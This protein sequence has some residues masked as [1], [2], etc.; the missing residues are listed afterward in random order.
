LTPLR[1][2]CYRPAMPD[3]EKLSEFS[4]WCAQHITGDEKVQA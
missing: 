3:R 2:L 4:A 1:P